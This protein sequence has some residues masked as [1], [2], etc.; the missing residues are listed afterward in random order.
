MEDK[1]LYFIAQQSP[2]S[3][4][5]SPAPGNT[6]T[7]TAPAPKTG[8]PPAQKPGGLS[9]FM[10]PLMMVAIIVGM[11]FM[12]I[13]PQRKEEKRKKE[14]LATLDKGDEVVTTSGIIGTVATVKDDT[15]FL[16]VGDGLRLQFLRSAVGEIRKKS[17]APSTAAP[18]E[19]TAGK[20]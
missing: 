12:V 7:T 9:E 5:G 2:L 3:G 20:K 10:F 17:G 11:Y 1:L 14:M 15:V 8:A 18:Q 6:T 19:K 4:G 16:K 13:R